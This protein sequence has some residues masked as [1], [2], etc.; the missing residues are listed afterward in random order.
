MDEDDGSTALDGP[1]TGRTAL[2]TG[3]VRGIGAATVEKLAALGAAVVATYRSDEAAAMAF[4]AEVT[5]RGVGTVEV[6][7]YELTAVSDEAGSAEELLSAVLAGHQAVDVLVLN[8]A[9]SYPHARLSEMSADALTAKVA[10]D[11]GAAHRLIAALASQM[12]ARGFG[13][14][15]LVGSLHAL[16]PTAPG[17]AASG[18]AKAALAGYLSFAVDELTGNGVTINLVEP[19]YVGTDASS[20]LPEQVLRTISALTPSGRTGQATDIAETIGWLVQ[21][22]AGFVNGARIPVAGGLNTAVAIPRIL[23]A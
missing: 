13:R 23:G 14:I 17:M 11:V 5:D 9:A 15:V 21:D 20:R 1:L 19:G 22:G 16:G 10:A 4:A 12:S 6:L 8:A 7:R 2:V 3:G 18:I